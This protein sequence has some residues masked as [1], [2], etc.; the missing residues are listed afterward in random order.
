MRLSVFALVGCF[1]LAAC[2]SPASDSCADGPAQPETDLPTSPFLAIWR[3]SDGYVR[4]PKGPYLRAAFWDDGR[5]IFSSNQSKW[6]HE[7]QH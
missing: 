1:L 4:K 7:L 6:G 2:A 3:H 5:V